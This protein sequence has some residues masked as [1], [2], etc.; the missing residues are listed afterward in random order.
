MIIIPALCVCVCTRSFL[1]V[2]TGHICWTCQQSLTGSVLRDFRVL[3]LWMHVRAPACAIKRVWGEIIWVARPRHLTTEASLFFCF[4]LFLNYYLGRKLGIGR[5]ERVKEKKK[6][7]KHKMSIKKSL[8]GLFFS[9]G[10]RFHVRMMGG[11]KLVIP[12]V[13][14]SL[15][16]SSFVNNIKTGR[17]WLIYIC[18]CYLHFHVHQQKGREKKIIWCLFSFGLV[19]ALFRPL[20]TID[21]SFPPL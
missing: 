19:P 16:L 17:G 18:F 21:A 2:N 15:F 9:S 5:R 1:V 6:I 3:M 10:T 11:V 8:M 7:K 4:F 12:L 14:F 13:V 20:Y